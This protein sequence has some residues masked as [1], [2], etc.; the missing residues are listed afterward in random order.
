MR[1]VAVI[2]T[3]NEE[4]HIGAVVE[5]AL[6]HV[7]AVVVSDGR[8]AD[9]TRDV[10]RKGGALVMNSYS[11]F[12]RQ[13][14]RGFRYAGL[15]GAD[16]VVFLDGD[17]QH[18][19]ADIPKLLEPIV[20]GR[21]DMVI[22][23]RNKCGVPAYRRF[24]LMLLRLVCQTGSKFKV[25]DAMSGFWA[26]RCDKL[27]EL[28]VDGWGMTL[29]LLIRARRNG[30]RIATVGV[31]FIYHDKYSDNSSVNFI[32]LWLIHLWM[33]IKL[34]FKYEVLYEADNKSN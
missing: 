12:G 25:G 15:M 32:W 16:V 33:I 26:V 8:S 3:L 31:D 29:E 11:G 30:G 28:A 14:R 4:G 2:P 17:G 18:N 7:D 19:T 5:G 34:R 9:K 27:P 23:C 6:K 13:L 24:G 10:A 22:A 21:S 20:Q 1:T